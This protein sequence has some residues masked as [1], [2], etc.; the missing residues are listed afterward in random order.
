MD[1]VG[2]SKLKVTRPWLRNRGGDVV[3]PCYAALACNADLSR[4]ISDVLTCNVS[5]RKYTR[6]MY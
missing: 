6:V 5:T 1:N 4:R 2:T 3:L